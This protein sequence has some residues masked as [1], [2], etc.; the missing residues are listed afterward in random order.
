M[1]MMVAKPAAA[2]MDGGSTDSDG[3]GVGS[4][5]DG[6]GDDTFSSMP[7]PD[8]TSVRPKLGGIAQPPPPVAEDGSR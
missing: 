6:R 4:G 1:A 5:D 8:P 7:P 2:T 3:P